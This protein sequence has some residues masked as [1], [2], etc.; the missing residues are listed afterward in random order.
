MPSMPVEFLTDEQATAFGRFAGCPRQADLERVFL[1]DDADS[2]LVGARRGAHNKLGFA[3]QLTT[4]RYL[5]TFLADP[6]DVP[7]R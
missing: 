3:L 4:V 6:Q 1:L 7:S 5:G 2:Q